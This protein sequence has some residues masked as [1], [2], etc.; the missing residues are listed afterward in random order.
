ISNAYV[1][2]TRFPVDTGTVLEE[3]SIDITSA[4]TLTNEPD[5]RKKITL[6]LNKFNTTAIYTVAYEPQDNARYVDFLDAYTD[7]Q[8]VV[9][10]VLLT[11]EFSG[12]DRQGQI[13]L[14]YFPYVDKQKLNSMDAS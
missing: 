8:G 10:S 1:A 2:Y 6:P 13:N 12:T 7:A 4:A 14:R 3:N 9:N 5:G 11:E